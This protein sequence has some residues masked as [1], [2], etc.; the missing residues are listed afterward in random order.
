MENW[1]CFFFPQKFCPLLFSS[2]SLL[3]H[4]H[5]KSTSKI[6]TI[7]IRATVRRRRR[8]FAAVTVARCYRCRARSARCHRRCPTVI[9]VASPAL[10]FVPPRLAESCAD[11]GFGVSCEIWLVLSRS[12]VSRVLIWWASSLIAAPT[13]EGV[14]D[15]R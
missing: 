11:W 7:G 2:S 3:L 1:E 5:T 9:A 8:S 10:E 13:I 12:E 15:L 6:S 14:S 4:T